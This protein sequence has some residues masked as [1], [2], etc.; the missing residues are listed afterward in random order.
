MYEIDESIK[1]LPIINFKNII[2][3]DFLVQNIEKKYD[4]IIGNPPYVKTSDGN[5]YLSFTKKC[6]EL[7]EENGELI[8]IIPSDFFKLTSASSLLN[9]M[10]KNGTFTHIFHP[11]NE[12]L[13]HSL[14]MGFKS[15]SG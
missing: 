4:T 1:F 8:F 2:F 10:M 15:L 11:H 5:L 12:N 14:D 3:G 6:Y 9:D 7:L 13:F